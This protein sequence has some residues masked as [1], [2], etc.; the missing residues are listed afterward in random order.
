VDHLSGERDAYSD[1]QACCLSHATW[2]SANRG[3]L[4][5]K[6]AAELLLLF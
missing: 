3:R 2:V 5:V 4:R 6:E 1:L